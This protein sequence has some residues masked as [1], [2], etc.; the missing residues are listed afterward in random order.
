ML[1]LEGILGNERMAPVAARLHR[2]K[3]DGESSI[4]LCGD[5][6]RP[7]RLRLSTDRGTRL[8]H[9]L[10][11]DQVSGWCALFHRQDGDRPAGRARDMRFGPG[12]EAASVGWHAATCTGR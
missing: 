5:R 12:R 6:Y 10:A 11:R 7:S 2:L 9:Q 1:R 4:C 8:R 3:H